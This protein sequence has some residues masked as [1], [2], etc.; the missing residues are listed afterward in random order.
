VV[1]VKPESAVN[2]L[3]KSSKAIQWTN[4]RI[5]TEAYSG[6]KGAHWLVLADA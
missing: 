2:V 5:I 6:I 3:L 1:G 4:N